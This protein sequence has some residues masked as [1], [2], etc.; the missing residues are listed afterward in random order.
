MLFGFGERRSRLSGKSLSVNG[1]L[2]DIRH[3]PV[4]AQIMA[5]EKGLI[6]YIPALGPEATVEQD[7]S[8]LLTDETLLA[9]NSRFVAR[10]RAKKQAARAD[11]PRCGLCGSTTKPLTHT[12]CC[13]NWICDDEENYVMFSFARNSCSR[14]HDR[15]TLCSS[16]YHEQHAGR[17]QDCAKC[18][19]GFETE[20][21]V[22]Y[23]TNEYNFDK[24]ENPPAFE[25]THCAECDTIIDLGNDGYSMAEGKYFCVKCGNKRMRKILRD[26]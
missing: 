13:N 6:P 25:P 8:T 22:Y 3:A 23:A 4:E 2:V 14:N 20:M 11:K 19:E 24:L 10:N 9:P 17:W 21:Y 15:Y 12:P 18:R 26:A 7:E 1:F 5:Y 16:H